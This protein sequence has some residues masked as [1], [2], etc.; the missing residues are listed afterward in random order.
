MVDHLH[1]LCHGQLF[2]NF[3]QVLIKQLHI[4]FEAFIS[5]EYPFHTDVLA[6]DLLQ[7]EVLNLEGEILD[8]VVSLVHRSRGVFVD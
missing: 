4:L 2:I 7:E 6:T 3:S 1:D 8:M 5:L